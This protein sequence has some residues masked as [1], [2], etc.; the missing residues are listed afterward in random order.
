MEQNLVN[1]SHAGI[2]EGDH[3]EIRKSSNL[4]GCGKSPDIQCEARGIFFTECR[5]LRCDS[6]YKRGDTVYHYSLAYARRLNKDT[7][8]DLNLT[9]FTY[10]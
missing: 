3:L 8:L 4:S 10:P 7:R 6:P 5:E 2:N 9:T 1:G